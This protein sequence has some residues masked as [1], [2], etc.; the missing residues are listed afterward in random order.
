MNRTT[1]SLCAAALVALAGTAQA[2]DH[3]HDPAPPPSH[4]AAPHAAPPPRASAT[5][6]FDAQYHHDH[7]Y[8]SHGAVFPRV[9]DHS[10]RIDHHGDPYYFHGGVW[11][12]RRGGSYA[13]V[14]P[15]LGIVVPLLPPGYTTV[16][17]GGTDY[18]YANGTYYLPDGSAGYTVV[19]PPP[20]S[21]PVAADDA[22][23]MEDD[24][25]VASPVLPAPVPPAAAT[26][27][28]PVVYPRNG[29]SA[30]QTEADRRACD[31]WAATQPGATAD[32]S[33]FQRAEAACLD[34]RGYTVR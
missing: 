21:P 4:A 26:P 34:G 6:H 20:G 30:A 29:Q 16:W 24:S 12:H 5:M 25:A 15:P 10:V 23:G 17:I 7:Y 9:P 11:F 27:P 32:A 13:V 14:A 2:Q 18:F 22:D 1:T 31:Q 19:A 8:P 28:A 33:I 3:A